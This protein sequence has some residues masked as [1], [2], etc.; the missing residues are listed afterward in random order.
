MSLL[1]LAFAALGYRLVDLQVQQHE[2]LTDLV[3]ANQRSTLVRPPKRADIRDVKGN[4]LATSLFVKTVFADPSQ[5][6]GH[7]VEIARVLAPLLN[8]PEPRLVEL[9]QPRSWTDASGEQHEREYVVL[10]K[11]VP[12]DEWDRMRA[13]LDELTLGVDPKALSR[14]ERRQYDAL[15][16]RV[17]NSVNVDPVDDQLRVYPN[18]SLAAHVLGYTGLTTETNRGA[19]RS[20]VVGKDGIELVLDSVLTGVGG[21]QQIRR[22]VHGRELVAHREQDVAPRPGLNVVLTVDCAVE[23]IVV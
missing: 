8:M 16:K 15:R 22:D 9:I 17:I 23:G 13:A 10:K 5:M 2:R 19:G 4:V 1:V 14:S 3:S 11:K 7:Q 20:E 21:W 6:E 12:P 18:G